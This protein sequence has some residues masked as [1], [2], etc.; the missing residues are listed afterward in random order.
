ME[1]PCAETKKD[2]EKLSFC[3]PFP[4][5]IL[6]QKSFPDMCIKI[7]PNWLEQLHLSQV[8]DSTDQ[9][10]PLEWRK[11]SHR[12]YLKCIP[13]AQKNPPLKKS[14]CLKSS[15]WVQTEKQFS[16]PAVRQPFARYFASLAF[17]WG[18]GPLLHR[19]DF[20]HSTLKKVYWQE[21]S[22]VFCIHT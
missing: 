16:S 4:A 19:A 20:L 17:S 7:P 10:I 2:C 18:K 12:R 11:A 8:K 22:F 1:V 3:L 13:V 6:S 9:N 15:D 5:I 14:D 21:P